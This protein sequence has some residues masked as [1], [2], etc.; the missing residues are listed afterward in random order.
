MLIITRPVR[1]PTSISEASKAKRWQEG[2]GASE[3]RKRTTLKFSSKVRI[4]LLSFEGARKQ[5]NMVLQARGLKLGIDRLHFVRDLP[6][7]SE[8]GT[9]NSSET[10]QQLIKALEQESIKYETFFK[11]LIATGIRRGECCGLK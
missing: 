11:L 8:I 3:I 4:S 2:P 7:T 5:S 9:S 1:R 6:R 10:V